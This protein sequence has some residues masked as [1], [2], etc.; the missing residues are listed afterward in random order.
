MKPS[1]VCVPRE[2]FGAAFLKRAEQG[3]KAKE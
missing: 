3:K 2:R 1:D